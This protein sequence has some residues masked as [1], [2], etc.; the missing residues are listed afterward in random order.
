[1]NTFTHLFESSNE[2]VL[3]EAKAGKTVNRFQAAVEKALKSKGL[4][5]LDD[6]QDV[7]QFIRNL[8]FKISA[9][10]YDAVANA[11]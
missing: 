5:S 2:E 10:E 3:F 7:E 1:V 4:D 6:V 9:S 8:N 11:I